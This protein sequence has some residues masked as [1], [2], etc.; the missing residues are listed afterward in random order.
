MKLLYVEDEADIRAIADFA[1]DHPLDR[2]R[3]F[4]D[5]EFGRILAFGGIVNQVHHLPSLP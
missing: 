2:A 3:Q 1:L 5:A 4:C